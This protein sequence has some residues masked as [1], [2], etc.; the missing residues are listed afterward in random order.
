MEVG[1]IKEL[2]I[3]WKIYYSSLKETRKIKCKRLH[4]L[5]M[6]MLM[7]DYNICWVV[8]SIDELCIALSLCLLPEG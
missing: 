6:L 8:S 7:V 3:C 1:L 2:L 5:A 4:W